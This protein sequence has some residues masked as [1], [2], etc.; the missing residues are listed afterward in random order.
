MS[1]HEP[2]VATLTKSE[3]DYLQR[4]ADRDGVS[5]EQAATSLGQ[6]A[7]ARIVKRKSGKTP[8]KVYSMRHK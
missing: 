1:E 3:R 5:V 2:D 6:R 7:L 4:I 8:A